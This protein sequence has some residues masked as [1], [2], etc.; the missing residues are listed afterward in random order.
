[1]KRRWKRTWRDLERQTVEVVGIVGRRRS[2]ELTLQ[3]HESVHG[4]IDEERIGSV[5]AS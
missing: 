5:V 3:S 4:E 1:M 2:G